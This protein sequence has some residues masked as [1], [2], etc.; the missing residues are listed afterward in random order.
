LKPRGGAAHQGRLGEILNPG[1]KTV[2]RIAQE[3]VLESRDEPG[4]SR[5]ESVL[6]RKPEGVREDL[7]R[8]FR[9]EVSPLLCRRRAVGKELGDLT[10]DQTAQ[11]VRRGAILNA[12]R[13]QD[14]TI[15]HPDRHA[16]LSS[17]EHA[18]AV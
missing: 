18:A 14:Q 16:G 9:V 12:K 4:G 2:G 1:K 7:A 6:A 13:I 5:Q 11:I 17:R 8:D 15:L 10:V 3:R